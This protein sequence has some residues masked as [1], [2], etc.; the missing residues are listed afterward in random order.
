MDEN[1]MKRE[2]ERIFNG[3]S[4]YIGST[5]L[6]KLNHIYTKVCCEKKET[7]SIRIY[8]LLKNFTLISILGM[9]LS[10]IICNFI[11]QLISF[12]SFVWGISLLFP[13]ILGAIYYFVI[14]EMEK[15]KDSSIR[16]RIFKKI[17]IDDNKE[18]NIK[19][20]NRLI[21]SIERNEKIRQLC[22]YCFLSYFITSF[23]LDYVAPES[24]SFITFVCTYVLE[25]GI[26]F[27][28]GKFKEKNLK[29]EYIIKDYVE[30]FERGYIGDKK[31]G[32]YLNPGNDMFEEV[33]N[34]NNYV[35]KSMLIDE[36]TRYS[37]KINK[38]ICVLKPKGFGKSTDVN[39]LVAYYSK[40][41]D[42]HSLFDSLEIS[43]TDSYEDHLNKHNVIYLNMQDFISLTENVNEMLSLITDAVISELLKIYD[44]TAIRPILSLYLS[45]IHA[46][47]KER[48]I[49]IID[50][51]DCVIRDTQKTEE[52][53]LMYLNFLSG[54][55][56]DKAYVEIAYITGIIPIRT[57]G[58]VNPLDMFDVISVIDSKEFSPFIGF[59]EEEVLD[60]CKINH[61]NFTKMKKE[62][63]YH[64]GNDFTVYS[65]FSVI[66]TINT[67][68]YENNQ[69]HK[70]YM[71]KIKD[72]MNNE[73][74]VEVDV[75][76]FR[77]DI[78]NMKTKD[79]ILTFLI[80]SGYLEYNSFRRE[81]TVP[82]K[83][84]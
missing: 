3:N 14:K 64:L 68:N 61:M 5:D 45:E 21:E 7:F 30:L 13:I 9:V 83:K 75:R 55:L 32:V 49:F 79:E 57:C 59:T 52:D 72:I 69:I 26:G 58:A 29:L 54:L 12:S 2:V 47:Y 11:D 23:V 53:K 66:S 8:I 39:M 6:S 80:Y 31:M 51:W 56:K 37:K 40:G 44:V 43:K 28:F 24:E 76:L 19:N 48:F 22:V 67:R 25:L 33:V 73:N 35:D 78:S 60:L 38:N 10:F 46:K 20:K 82:Y 34:K 1:E 41:C 84:Q 77:N 62:F 27:I 4:K 63:K 71:D 65:P 81:V 36:I 74:S 16:N 70:E 18:N 17:F 50:E 15:P 42:S